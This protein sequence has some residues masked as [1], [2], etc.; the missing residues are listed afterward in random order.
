MDVLDV[1]ITE[2]GSPV[3]QGKGC[4]KGIDSNENKSCIWYTI[5][6]EKQSVAPCFFPIL[7]FYK[8]KHK[9]LKLVSNQ[10]L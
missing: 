1:N 9:T 6:L 10:T 5:F 2:S 3:F 7:W 8:N 4:A